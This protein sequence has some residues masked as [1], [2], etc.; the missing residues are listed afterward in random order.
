[1]IGF[2]GPVMAQRY[3]DISSGYLTVDKLKGVLLCITLMVKKHK[4]FLNIMTAES[5]WR[6]EGVVRETFMNL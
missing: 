1:M 4:P 6:E 2:T 5:V 3:K